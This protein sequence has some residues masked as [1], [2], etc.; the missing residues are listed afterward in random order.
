MTVCVSLEWQQNSP[1]H[2]VR[3]GCTADANCEVSGIYPD[4]LIDWISDTCPQGC[5]D[6]QSP[7]KCLK[8]VDTYL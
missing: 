6:L 2:E 3:I 7:V 8:C 1:A 5:T 4:S